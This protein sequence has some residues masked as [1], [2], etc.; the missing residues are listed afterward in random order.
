MRRRPIPNKQNCL[1]THKTDS[2]THFQSNFTI[3]ALTILSRLWP[4]TREESS[5]VWGTMVVPLEIE[6]VR[7][8]ALIH[9]RFSILN[10]NA[11]HLRIRAAALN[12]LYPAV[13]QD[14]LDTHSS[15][16]VWLKHLQE[17]TAERWLR[18]CVEYSTTRR[19][20]V[21]VYSPIRVF[22]QELFPACKETQIVR[23]ITRCLL[24]RC[25]LKE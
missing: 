15:V 17:N 3:K 14:L 16:W 6:F 12:T 20:V 8:L 21:A 24:P 11:H 7:Q 22:L 19:V 13:I 10:G 5:L 25:A 9:V 4:I 18:K 2:T 23:I 1:R